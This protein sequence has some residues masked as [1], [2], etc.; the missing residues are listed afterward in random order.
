MSWQKMKFE[1]FLKLFEVLVSNDVPYTETTLFLQP[2][3]LM[4]FTKKLLSGK[5]SRQKL[6]LRSLSRRQNCG[7]KNFEL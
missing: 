3:A 2:P 5:L 4:N 7:H 1:F 6:G